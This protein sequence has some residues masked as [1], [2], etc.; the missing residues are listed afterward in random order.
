MCTV[1]YIPL[2][3][4]PTGSYLLTTNRDERLLRAAAEAPA[5]HHVFDAEVLMPVDPQGKGTWV[6]TS[7]KG[8]TI[9]LLNGGLVKHIPNPP[10]RH[11]RGLVVTGYF[12]FENFSSFAKGFDFSNLEPFTLVVVEEG[13]LYEMRWDGEQAYF[14]SP[15]PGRPWLWSSV[16]LYE[17]EII[18]WREELFQSWIA[19]QAGLLATKPELILDFHQFK[20]ES[21]EKHHIL[22][23]RK[24]ILK[25]V[26]ITSIL[27]TRDHLALRYLDLMQRREQHLIK[28][29][30]KSLS[31]V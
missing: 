18:Q 31:L 6:A 24:G 8:R 2:T 29:K 16:T 23:E 20:E 27:H 3:G 17:P 26:S 4:S 15:D 5:W 25:T 19:Q 14:R 21:N 12:K 28:L 7:G 10:Y 30:D 11:S 22:I 9:C 13:Q 1:S